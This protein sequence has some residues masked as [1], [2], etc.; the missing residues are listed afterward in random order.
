MRSSKAIKKQS[1]SNQVQQQ[2]DEQWR[3]RAACKQ[4]QVSSIERV[5][6]PDEGGNHE[7]ITG[8]QEAIKK[9]SRSKFRPSN[10][11]RAESDKT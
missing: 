1:R 2:V 8:N 5:S 4:K 3:T 7:V 6:A 9:Q 11:T 10:G